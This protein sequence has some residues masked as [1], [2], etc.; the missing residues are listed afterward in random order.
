MKKRSENALITSS[1]QVIFSDGCRVER[2]RR[3]RNDRPGLPKNRDYET[4][5]DETVLYHGDYETVEDTPVKKINTPYI[6][7]SFTAIFTLV[8]G[9]YSLMQV[10]NRPSN[11]FAE[12]SNLTT[13]SNSSRVNVSAGINLEQLANL[14]IT[15][16]DWS[17]ISL[18]TFRQKLLKLDGLSYSEIV[19]TKWFKNV[20][21]LIRNEIKEQNMSINGNVLAGQSPQPL[22]QL[23]V[24]MGVTVP[25]YGR[26]KYES[27][28]LSI[29][30]ILAEAEVAA[31]EDENAHLS[32]SEETDRDFTETDINKVLA[33][34]ITAYKV[35][36]TEQVLALYMFDGVSE[37]QAIGV[38]KKHLEKLFKNS[39][40][41]NINFSNLKWQI[42]GD[43][44]VGN[45]KYKAKIVLNRGR[46]M[47]TINAKTQIKLQLLQG[48]LLFA[49]LTLVEA[50]VNVA[51]ATTLSE[52]TKVSKLKNHS[53]KKTIQKTKSKTKSS[54]AKLAKNQTKPQNRK[55]TDKHTKPVVVIAVNS[56]KSTDTAIVPVFAD[57][58]STQNKRVKYPTKAEL[59]IVVETF[60]KAYDAGDIN[61]LGSLFA[62]NA[63][64]ND[65]DN[66]KEIRQDYVDFFSKTTN[67]QIVIK[68]IN[69]TFF[70]NQARGV[71]KMRVVVVSTSNS[72][73]HVVNGTIQIKTKKVKNKVLITHL[74]HKE[75]AELGMSASN[76]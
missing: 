46:G 22:L 52:K 68:A 53:A 55:A 43:K 35:G 76:N 66:L 71:G 20:S 30:K 60:V 31:S 33:Q 1:E 21:F 13:V 51:K 61:T 25:E 37:L 9:G 36:N 49:D 57:P 75:G 7:L 18:N 42:E 38:L 19:T 62:E 47:Q 24:V 5:T 58:T 11:S 16:R 63:K 59:K 73:A 54:E 39:S 28:A 45:G 69:W 67:R 70:E 15:E 34:Y 12:I 27:E 72:K 10:S 3:R 14:L 64:T 8:L 23:A 6:I 32:Q 50:K 74:Y 29:E 26:D 44:A 40:Q 4:D 2:S 41:R 48:K 56:K 17:D 65:Q